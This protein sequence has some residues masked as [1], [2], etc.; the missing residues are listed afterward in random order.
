MLKILIFKK[1]RNMK[2]KKKLTDEF[3]AGFYS[4]EGFTY[5]GLVNKEKGY[6]SVQIGMHLHIRDKELLENIRDFIGV[7]VVKTRNN[8]TKN[9]KTQ[10]V[11]YRISNRKD[12]LTFAKRIFPLCHGYKVKQNNEFIEKLEEISNK[13]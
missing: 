1:E 11:Q 5:I 2:N 9:G 13:S 6:Y 10:T 4:G 7:G 8:N 12:C 3:I